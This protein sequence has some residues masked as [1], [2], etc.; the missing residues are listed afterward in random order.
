[1]SPKKTNRPTAAEKL[2]AV[3]K[4]CRRT[5]ANAAHT[6]TEAEEAVA[7]AGGTLPPLVLVVDSLDDDR[8]FFTRWLTSNGFRVATAASGTEALDVMLRVV[9]AAVLL[10]LVLPDF[11]GLDVVRT[12]RDDAEI[13]DIPIIAISA[14]LPRHSEDLAVSAGCCGFLAKPCPPHD[15]LQ[16]LRAVLRRAS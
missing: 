2:R 10:D 11:D 1:L 13:G 8:E 14:S 12:L 7:R 5:L 6:L 9:P 15:L 16:L 3:L 4:S